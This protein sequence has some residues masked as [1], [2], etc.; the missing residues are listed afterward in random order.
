MA[1]PA[2]ARRRVAP[3]QPPAPRRGYQARLACG[4][5]LAPKG[6]LRSQAGAGAEEE[7]VPEAVVKFAED[8]VIV[9]A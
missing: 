4:L 3:S 2:L 8:A 7:P 6:V 9:T 5:V 1:L